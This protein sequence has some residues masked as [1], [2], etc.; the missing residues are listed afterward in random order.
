MTPQ[1]LL[2]R[3][4]EMMADPV[5]RV[6]ALQRIAKS[7]EG[8]YGTQKMSA[9]GDVETVVEV[10][11]NT[12]VTAIKEVGRIY[13]RYE[14]QARASRPQTSITLNIGELLPAPLDPEQP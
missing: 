1:Q 12:A 11:L 2:A 4:D 9:K 13:E 5:Q 7:A 6:A 8:G 3:L 10:A 14:D